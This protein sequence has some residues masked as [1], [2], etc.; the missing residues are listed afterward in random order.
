MKAFIRKLS[1]KERKGYVNSIIYTIFSF[2]HIIITKSIFYH[3]KISFIT[4]IF[5][6][7]SLLIMMSFYR[8]FRL[9]KKFKSIQKENI[10]MNF[11]VGLN[12]FLSFFFL[13]ASIDSTSLTNIVFISRLYP[14]LVMLNHT[15]TKP[16]NISNHQLVSFIIYFFS[17]LI[18]FFPALYQDTGFGV[19][20][21]LLS[22]I[23]KFSSLTYLSNAK[24]L[25]V[26]LL[27]LN[28]G[29]FNAF[30]GGLIVVTTF[31]E[32]EHVGKFMWILIILNALCTY[33]MK[34]FLNKV[35][36]GNG[37]EQKLMFLSVIALIFII[38][39]DFYVFEQSFYYNDLVLIFSFTE[40]YFFYKTV[41]KVIKTNTNYS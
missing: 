39:F 37:G 7:G 26:D 14:F 19:V 36:K 33:F 15:L 2:L 31:D 34:I 25:N 22:I 41:K 28:I 18:I 9:M 40:I 13:I 23:F 30:F 32:I 29:F 5:I 10:K 20:Y 12:S 3:S 38:P 17:F 11:M 4:L 8:I 21:A 6:S 1:I 27:M 16:E 24:G 35:L